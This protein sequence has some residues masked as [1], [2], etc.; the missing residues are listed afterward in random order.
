MPRTRV[1]KALRLLANDPRLGGCG[2]SDCRA[3]RGSGKR[4]PAVFLRITFEMHG[5][6][7]SLRMVGPHDATLM[8][9]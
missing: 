7:L 1:E 8:N 9:P 6:V 5:D 3:L 2:S 4:A